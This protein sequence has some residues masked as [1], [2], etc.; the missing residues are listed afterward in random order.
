MVQPVLTYTGVSGSTVVGQVAI[1]P[2]ALM[3]IAWQV[4][5]PTAFEVAT[6]AGAAARLDQAPPRRFVL[7][8]ADDQTWAALEEAGLA[9]RSGLRRGDR[10]DREL[11]PAGANLVRA[12]I[13]AEAAL[14]VPPRAKR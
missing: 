11:S 1:A 2:S 8:P 3:L 14:I 6:Q 9:R 4:G 5:W 7:S 12:A 13:R 10:V